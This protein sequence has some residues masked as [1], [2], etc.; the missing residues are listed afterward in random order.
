M[1]FDATNA[2]E[3]V[4]ARERMMKLRDRLANMPPNEFSMTNWCGTACCI[5]GLS[6][7]MF[8]IQQ[9]EMMAGRVI[10]LGD[11]QSKALFYPWKG[12]TT[13]YDEAKFFSPTQ[14]VRVLDHLIETGDVDW[15]RR[16]AP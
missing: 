13:T 5:G 6:E 16:G 1:A 2:P 15:S 12:T 11:E 10:G 9:T 14:A 3:E 8:G 7:M 4:Q